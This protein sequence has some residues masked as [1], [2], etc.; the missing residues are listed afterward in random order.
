MMSMGNLDDAMPYYREALEGK[1]RVLGEDHLDTLTSISHLEGLLKSMG[2]FAEAEVLGAEAVRGARHS[3][4]QGHWRTGKFLRTHGEIL[5]A[6][7]RFDEAEAELLEAHGILETARGEE[8]ERTRKVVQ[9][10]VDLYTAWHASEPDEPYNAKAAKWRAKLPP[11]EPARQDGAQP[12]S[13]AE[14]AEQ[15][16]DNND[17]C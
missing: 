16:D 14:S 4:A 15:G 12:D 13:D 2:K 17:G 11:T 3:L 6:L 1:R 8:H 7:K 5:T 9:A 10:L